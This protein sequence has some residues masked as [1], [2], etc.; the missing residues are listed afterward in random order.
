MR[1]WGEL[2]PLSRHSTEARPFRRRCKRDPWIIRISL[3]H[4][5]MWT[6]WSGTEE[7]PK[8]LTFSWKVFIPFLLARR[9]PSFE[10]D[11][12]RWSECKCAPV[13]SLGCI[14]PPAGVRALQIR[15][16]RQIAKRR[17]WLGKYCQLVSYPHLF[18]KFLSSIC[19]HTN[20]PS[21]E[22]NEII[23][24]HGGWRKCAKTMRLK[25]CFQV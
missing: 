18:S 4:F 24:Q 8:T 15:T 19:T 17:S 6:L 23:L 11:E 16:L 13:Y 14:I 1:K 2:Y 20:T 7:L 21:V 5:W 9:I 10:G 25:Q 22:G 3:F 12:A